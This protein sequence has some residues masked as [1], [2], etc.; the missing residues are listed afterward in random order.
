MHLFLFL[1]DYFISDFP[2]GTFTFF[3]D[4]SFT[5]T[6]FGHVY[7]FRYVGNIDIYQTI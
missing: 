5:D 1:I 7:K 4:I 3:Q 2:Q 6:N